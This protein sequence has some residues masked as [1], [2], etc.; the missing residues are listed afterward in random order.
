MLEL[1][2]VLCE[3]WC[4]LWCGGVSFGRSFVNG[5]G[6]DGGAN[7]GGGIEPIAGL[8]CIANGENV[9]MLWL[10]QYYVSK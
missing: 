9:S 2:D 1:V 8:A 7:D 5:G 6:R 4:E 3:W 10:D